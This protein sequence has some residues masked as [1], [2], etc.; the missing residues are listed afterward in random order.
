MALNFPIS[1]A[2]GEIYENFR[3]NAEIGA[4]QV[5]SPL[6]LNE[7][8]DVTAPSPNAGDIVYWNGSGWVSASP[9]EAD[10]T[11]KNLNAL[12]WMYA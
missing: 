6:T 4:W 3:W 12:F 8:E 5:F 11:D 7:I 10:L 1:P 2:D 9:E